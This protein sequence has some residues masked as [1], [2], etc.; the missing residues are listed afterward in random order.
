VKLY[1]GNGSTQTISGLGFDPDL[2]YIKNRTQSG[3][4]PNMTDT[5]RGATKLLLTDDTDAE[6][7]D[8]NDVSA[9]TTGGFSVGSN[10]RVNGSTDAMV[11]W[12]WDAGSSTV[13]NTDG[14]ISSQVRANASAGFSVVAYTGTGAN[15][16]VGHGLGVAPKLFICKRRDS[17]GQWVVFTTAIDGSLDFLYLEKTDAKVDDSS[18]A[19]P[20]ATVFSLGSGAN[21]NPSG[22]TMVAYCFA[23]VAGYSSMSSFVANANSDGPFVYLSFRP[24]FLLLKNTTRSGPWM[25]LD[26]SRDS[27]NV[28]SN[29]L[30]ANDADAE[31]STQPRID[32][33]SNG[34]K[35]RAGSG[36]T[37]NDVSGDVYVYAAWAEAPFQYARAR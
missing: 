9:F 20:T 18:L 7:T 10:P 15:A 8:V 34:F 11:A 29:F 2:I 21:S 30:E 36:F 12:C 3:R 23:P 37:P 33:L 19:L 27:Y 4:S 1:T 6:T 25:L 5:V 26:S 14:S 17:T 31:A 16:T 32:F 22:G 13:T 24:K 28:A 35:V